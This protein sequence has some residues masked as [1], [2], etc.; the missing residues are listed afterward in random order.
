MQVFALYLH[1]MKSVESTIY[2]EHLVSCFSALW[3]LPTQCT[4]KCLP[5]N[6]CL[7]PFENL[8]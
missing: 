2:G 8:V 6:I 1:L 7:F 3:Y 4:K 5:L